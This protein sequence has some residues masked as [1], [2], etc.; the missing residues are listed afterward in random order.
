MTQDRDFARTVRET[1]PVRN[2][3]STPWDILGQ[4]TELI[5]CGRKLIIVWTEEV[6]RMRSCLMAVSLFAIACTLAAQTTPS[7]YKVP[8]MPDGHPALEGTYDIAVALVVF[9]LVRRDP[10]AHCK[11]TLPAN[12]DVHPP[13]EAHLQRLSITG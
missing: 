3:R 4:I 8:R 9:W 1:F 7:G 6:M 11:P 12:C 5:I 13:H 2:V 10:K